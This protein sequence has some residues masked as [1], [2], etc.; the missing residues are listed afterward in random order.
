M[1]VR[2][3]PLKSNFTAG[4]LEPALHAREDLQSYA[5]G[6]KAIENMVVM[7]QG[8]L[9]RRPGT[10]LVAAL[11]DE[12]RKGELMPLKF[13]RL[14]ARMLILNAGVA[15]VGKNRGLVGDGLGGV[16]EFPHP[17]ADVDLPNLR[18][19][20]SA[21]YLYV[22]SGD[23][24]QQIVRNADDDWSVDPFK[25]HNGPV[26]P[27]N[28][29]PAKRL[30][31]DGVTGTIN[32]SANFDVFEAGHV[33]S[34]WRLDEGDLG[35]VPY[36]TANEVVNTMAAVPA[37]PTAAQLRA[38][39]RRYKNNIYAAITP[40]DAG[41]V[42]LYCGV[43]PPTQTYGDFQSQATCVL[44]RFVSAG[45]GYVRIAAVADARHA[46][47]EVQ[48]IVGLTVSRLP[49]SLLYKDTYRWFEAAWSD[50]RGW[51]VLAV[52]NQ[53]RL[54]WL[55]S[56]GQL[57]LGNP[58]DYPGYET[59]PSDDPSGMVYVELR[60]SDGSTI[61]PRW[62]FGSGWI[63]IGGAEL[64]HV[65]RA[66]SGA[67]DAI[68][69]Q[70]VGSVTDSASGSAWA[71][72]T[73]VDSG[74]AFVSA[75]R[76]RLYYAKIARLMQQ[77]EVKDITIACPHIL[78]GLAAG[79]AYQ[80]DPHRIIWGFSENGDLWGVTF[81]PD[82][83]VVGGHRHPMPGAVI[84][85]MASMPTADGLGNEVWM[86]VRRT[87][88]A[89]VRRFIEV[90]T[91]FP[92]P[93]SGKP[94]TAEGAW[95]VDCGVPYDGAPTKRLEG[96]PFPDGTIVRVFGE[97]QWL[98]DVAVAGGAVDLTRTTSKGVVGL[99]I[100]FRAR[101]L[102]MEPSRPGVSARGGVKQATHATADFV[103]SW[104]GMARTCGEDVENE[105]VEID[106][107]FEDLFPD[108]DLTPGAP[109][110]LF[111]GRKVFPMDG[112]HLLRVE[113]EYAGDHPYPVTLL[114]LSPDVEQSEV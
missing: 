69:P 51:P 70:S 72:A 91:D 68:T 99:P 1:S 5:N 8:G 85:A 37:S 59:R 18:W 111:T 34:L 73:L 101:T 94:K 22:A 56:R 89:T 58:A 17:F 65:V 109:V 66:T 19:V 31:V 29:D 14:D 88:G 54:G 67:S 57:W 79:A 108:G 110:D 64:E 53:Q 114:G 55:G 46:T 23:Q 90:M 4:E 92:P 98:G 63:V 62:A 97:G 44:W 30:L 50:K 75:S 49:D 96:L 28:L 74:V 35:I 103:E 26:L 11:K 40:P 93:P 10:R 105:T 12:T 27:Q 36:W 42:A 2:T 60:S 71:R 52:F 83:S 80:H 3:T 16:Y 43:N 41:Q 78:N 102:P 87:F 86:I 106:E 113:I 13:S 81:R 77:L 47:A 20:E 25:P 7:P 82:Q 38:S 15:R 32:I 21:D 9:T 61:L 107:N 76:Q 104:G 84:E 39:Y 6:A 33:G 48:S 112:P 45:Y 24:P 100:A 95:Y